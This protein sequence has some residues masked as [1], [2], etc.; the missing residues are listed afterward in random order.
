MSD[1]TLDMLVQL[2]ALAIEQ[3][4]N[5]KKQVAL[6]VNLC[7]SLTLLTLENATLKQHLARINSETELTPENFAI[8]AKAL[9]ALN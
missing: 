7:N 5:S 6:F 4:A 8:A 2:Q 9:A 1:S 3:D